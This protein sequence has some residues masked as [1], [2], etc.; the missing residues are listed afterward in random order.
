MENELTLKE[1]ELLPAPSVIDPGE[2][3]LTEGFVERAAKQVE[4]RARLIQTA[5]KALKS[6]DIQNFDGKPYIEGEGAARIMSVIRGFKVGEAKFTVENIHPHFFIECAIPMEFMG[7]STVALGDCATADPFFTGKDGNSGMYKRHLERT[8]SEQMA[9]RLLLGD[10]KK[11]ARENAI[12][13]GVTELLGLKGLSWDDL[14]QLGFGVASAG[15]NVQFKKGA[16][17]GEIKTVKLAEAVSVAIGSTVNFI[18]TLVKAEERQVGKDK[19]DITGYT[20][21]D[22]EHEIVVQKWGK[23]GSYFEGTEVYCEKVNV[24]EYNGK[25]QYSASDVRP[26]EGGVGDE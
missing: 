7:A 4:L 21:T 5:L 3:N 8:G 25:R 24:G 2:L 12:S 13:R 14:Q 22:G 11:K 26:A 15:S 10:A 19:K 9:A 23:S 18:G 17:G 6:H 16:S 1:A 20:V